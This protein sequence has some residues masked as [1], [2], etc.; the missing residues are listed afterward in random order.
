MNNIT[1]YKNR[2]LDISK[3]VRMYRCLNRKGFIFSLNQNGKVVGHTNNIVL[4]DCNLIVLESGKKRCLKE[5]QR[6][7]HAFV[8][9]YL[10]NENDIKLS[11]SF[12]LKYNPYENKNFYTSIAGEI[13]KCNV[14]YIKN[15]KIYCQI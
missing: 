15:N 14:V 2:E 10:G 1:P 12:L 9:G 13:S 7:I 5:K 8:E 4:K 11:F 6:N 3:K